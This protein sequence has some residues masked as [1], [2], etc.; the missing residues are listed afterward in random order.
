MKI[1]YRSRAFGSH[2]LVE[3]T[4]YEIRDGKIIEVVYRF[5]YENI[6]N[7]S[8][9]YDGEVYLSHDS[10]HP[11]AKTHSEI[12]VKFLD[13]VDAVKRHIDQPGAIVFLKLL[14]LVTENAGRRRDAHESEVARLRQSIHDARINK[15]KLDC[16]KYKKK[17]LELSIS[18]LNLQKKNLKTKEASALME[19][20]D[21][22]I[23]RAADDLIEA[24]RE[25][26]LI[27]M[28]SV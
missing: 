2:I 12:C 22:N 24:R 13:V 9:L 8:M 26:D 10:N 19:K 11:V 15:A 3:I 4:C 23:Q 27:R 14:T 20:I 17:G 21:L 25:Y 16:K 1:T 28:M 7:Y 6:D 18:K 5:T